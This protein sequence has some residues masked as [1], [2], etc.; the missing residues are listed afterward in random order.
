MSLTRIHQ[1]HHACR[2]T[3]TDADLQVQFG[4][5]LEEVGEMLDTVS[6]TSVTDYVDISQL[7]KDL[8]RIATLLKTR[9]TV[10]MEVIDRKGLL[11]SLADQVVTGVGVGYCANMLVL[12]GIA[13]VNQSNWTKFGEDGP[14]RLP[15]GK[16][17]KGPF[18]IPPDLEG[19]Y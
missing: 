16:I 2:P 11:D 13:R 17:G 8:A 9:E 19:C 12:V 10:K 6:I 5:H 7:K 1:W 14:V 4:C 3:P 15:G 18:Y